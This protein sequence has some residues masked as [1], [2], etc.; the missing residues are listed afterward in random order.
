M[1]D[2]RFTGYNQRGY[3]RPLRMGQGNV[4]TGVCHS[5]DGGGGVWLPT[6][7]WDR[8]TPSSLPP[9]RRQTSTPPAKRQ[10]PPARRQT[11]LSEDRRST[12]GWHASYLES[13]LVLGRLHDTRI[14]WVWKPINNFLNSKKL[15]YSAVIFTSNVRPGS[16]LT[17]SSGML[18]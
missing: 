15:V 1:F 6:M 3:Y 7:P 14:Q 2:Q 9:A 11:P 12:G 16:E 10:T 13:I 17:Y 8:Q 18:Q 5:V 4:F